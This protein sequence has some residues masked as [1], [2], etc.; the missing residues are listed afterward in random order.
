MVKSP[1][2][3][4]GLSLP[5][6]LEPDPLPTIPHSPEGGG[7]PLP[8]PPQPSPTLRALLHPPSNTSAHDFV[9]DYCYVMF[10]E[11][12]NT[13]GG[14]QLSI[15]GNIQ[16]LWTQMKHTQQAVE[17]CNCHIHTLNTQLNE[18]LQAFTTLQ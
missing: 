11:P 12:L 13:N 1:I 4:A 3:P 18:L 8:T 9:E 10:H 7:R 15:P 5:Q 14:N 6:N 2:N 16:A 17:D